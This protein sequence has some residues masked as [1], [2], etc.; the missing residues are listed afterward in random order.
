MEAELLGDRPPLGHRLPA[1]AVDDAHE[2][3][4]ALDV[5]QE[6]VA[7]AASLVGALDQ[8]GTSAMTARRA[9]SSKAMTPRF[10]LSVVNG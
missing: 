3:P 9:P 5:A 7:E 8:P 1:G 2:H 6:L 10:G 4:G